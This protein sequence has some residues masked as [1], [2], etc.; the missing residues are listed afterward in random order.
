MPAK[1]VP[2]L[3]PKLAKLDGPDARAL[4]KARGCELHELYDYERE[5]SVD[6]FD[7]S[8]LYY[9]LYVPDVNGGHYPDPVR[10]DDMD[11]V[12][13]DLNSRPVV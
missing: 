1:D 4:A 13:L 8:P 6:S 5:I 7:D 11:E 10:F 2:A 12:E 9:W 3:M